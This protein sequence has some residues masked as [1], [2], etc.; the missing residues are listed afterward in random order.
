MARAPSFLIMSV[1]LRPVTEDDYAF[2]KVHFLGINEQFEP[3][4]K[5]LWIQQHLNT[6]QIITFESKDVGYIWSVVIKRLCYVFEFAINSEY[7]GKGVGRKALELLREGALKKGCN[8]IGLH[9]EKFR[10]AALGLYL[11]VGFKSINDGYSLAICFEKLK[12][13]STDSS[14]CDS[15]MV[16]PTLLKS[17][18]EIAE[19]KYPMIEGATEAFANDAY[20]PIKMTSS[21]EIC[22]FCILGTEDNIVWRLAVDRNEDVIPFL[23]AVSK[24][25]TVKTEIVALWIEKNRNFVDY[26][27]GNVPSAKELEVYIYMIWEL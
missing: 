11:S 4:S 3:M 16:Q 13:L 20:V 23:V 18:W 21:N 10:E 6:A 17:D 19:Q 14:Q 15:I 12:S 1:T 7:R 24:M 25:L 27:L 22:G 26:I 2:Y 9:C 5:G 8:S